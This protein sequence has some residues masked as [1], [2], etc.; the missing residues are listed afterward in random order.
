[1][2]ATVL[3]SWRVSDHLAKTAIDAAIGTTAAIVHAD[4][5]ALV[6]GD[7]LAPSDSSQA[8]A[9]DR[10]LAALVSSGRILRIKV[11][12]PTG[13]VL[14]SDLHAL[15]GRSF[16]VDD[17]LSTALSG[18]AAATYSTGDDAENEFEQG[19]A[20]ELLSIYLPIQIGSR[21]VGAYEI[22]EDAAPIEAQIGA[23]RK[24]VFLIVG[25]MAVGLL[26]LV[27]AA[28]SVA[29]R[30]LARQNRRLR[31]QAA[32]E[33]ILITDLRRSE[34][35]FRSLVQ[36]AADVV[37]V[38]R[39]DGT[40]AYESPPVERVLGYEVHERVGRAATDFV[41]PDDRAAIAQVFDEVTRAPGLQ[42]AVEFGC[43]HHDG[44]WRTIAGLAQNLLE[45]PAVRGIVVNYRDVTEPKALANE[46]EHRAFHDSLT[47]LANRALFGDRLSHALERR[48]G[49]RESLAVL[50]LDLDD[51]KTVNDSLG[52][53]EGDRLLVGVA[54]RLRSSLRAADSIARMGGDEFA[55]LLDDPPDSLAPREVGR[56]L[57][58]ALIAPFV[59]AGKEVF[60]RASIGIA[61]GQAGFQT[62]DELLRNADL[63]MYTAK[64]NGKNRIEQFEPRM[65]HEASTRLALKGDLERALERR[66]FSL[67]YQPIFELASGRLSGAEA[68]VRWHHPE[69]GTVQPAEFIPVA[70]ETGLIVPLG[71][72]VLD[73]ACRTAADW[74]RGRPGGLLNLSV[75][76]SGRQIQRDGYVHEVAAT[77]ARSGLRPSRLLLEFTESLLMQDSAGAML[78]GLKALGIR[79]AIDDFGTGYSSLSYLRNFPIDVIKIDRSFVAAT[80]AG[81]DLAPV[82][83]SIVDLGETL[84]LETI[85]E[86]IE[87]AAQLASLRTIGATSGQGFFLAR[88]LAA[89]EIAALIDAGESARVTG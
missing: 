81:V 54:E 19:L 8:A 40:I 57:L 27:W 58:A 89:D 74:G 31:E 72:W 32:T 70:E 60:V 33:Q 17:D 42:I 49:T 37:M 78:D 69:R 84:H 63:S 67:V 43:L 36:N 21:I 61:T 59:L 13:T 73:E 6:S 44:S 14:Y 64:R 29:S 87:D 83:R 75:N 62:A 50:F 2:L 1:M 48:P 51:F 30:L 38:V 9:I 55:I 18:S 82:V 5:D 4:L 25:A 77:L 12:S 20:N 22:Y 15:I 65:H 88:P 7:G 24:D 26:A 10:E 53:G 66:E 34:E 85:A 68:L 45:D 80:S 46:L 47:G 79:L 41:H 76:V 52:H 28:F 11:W 3:V 23:T 71:A 16:P 35:R 56:R 86:G 39:E